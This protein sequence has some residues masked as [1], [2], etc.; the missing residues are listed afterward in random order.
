[1]IKIISFEHF[2]LHRALLRTHNICYRKQVRVDEIFVHENFT[3]T[4]SKVNDIALLRL[5]EN[6]HQTESVLKKL[7]FLFE[8]FLCPQWK[9]LIF[10][11]SRRPA[12]P[13][14]ITIQK[15][16]LAMSMVRKKLCCLW[17]GD[18]FVFYGEEKILFE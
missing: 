2:R 1:M 13:L 7:Y 8:P 9:G 12:Y 11:L 15:E 18:N 14:R 17:R 3:T 4:G 16:V 6:Q 5:G 10:P